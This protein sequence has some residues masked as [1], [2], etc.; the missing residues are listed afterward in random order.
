MT[1][2]Q[3][4]DKVWDHFI[5]KKSGPGVSNFGSASLEPVP[6][7]QG[8]CAVGVLLSEEDRNA[9]D[10]M[11]MPIGITITRIHMGFKPLSD[12]G[13]AVFLEGNKKDMGARLS[14]VLQSLQASHDTAYKE[15]G[16]PEHFCANFKM[17][18]KSIAARFELKLPE[19][20]Q[21]A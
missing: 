5:T 18:L 6:C 4:F 20:E 2:Q 9:L 15:T 10:S 21:H 7:Y 1:P 19:E 16:S 13:C 8:P 12:A 3:V 14:E 11:N 17:R